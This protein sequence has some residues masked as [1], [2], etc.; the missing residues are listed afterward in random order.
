MLRVCSAGLTT[1]WMADSGMR[2]APWLHCLLAISCGSGC[3]QESS[4]C[5]MFSSS[6]GCLVPACADHDLLLCRVPMS[7]EE[8]IGHMDSRPGISRSSR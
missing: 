4:S 8:A 5:H 6:L 3:Y 7:T 2:T 1:A